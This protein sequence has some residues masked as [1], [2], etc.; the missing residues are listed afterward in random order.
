MTDPDA[1][2]KLARRARVCGGCECEF[3][4]GDRVTSALYDRED[5]FARTDWCADCFA[6]PGRDPEPYSWWTARMPEPE[7]KRAAFDLGVAREFLDRLLQ[8]DA[9]ERASLR[10]LLTLMLMR[11]RGVKVLEQFTDE[12]GEVMV[13]TMP[14]DER[15][16]EIPCPEIDAAESESLRDE[17]GRLFDL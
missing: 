15:P 2:W 8:E 9:P 11:K 7:T 5:A 14:P 10:Y 12:R 17:L 6:G 4:G 1:G 13:V 3:A 16:W